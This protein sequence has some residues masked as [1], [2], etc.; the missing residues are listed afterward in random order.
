MWKDNNCVQPKEA[1]SSVTGFATLADNIFYWGI[2]RNITSEGGASALS[3]VQKLKEEVEELEQALLAGD[4]EE[5]EKR[6]GTSK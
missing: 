5:I 3:Q 1:F 4:G 2:D 6:L